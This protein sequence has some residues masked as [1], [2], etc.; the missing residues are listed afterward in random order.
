MP[1]GNFLSRA[2]K[3]MKDVSEINKNKTISSEE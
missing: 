2:W 1:H 3:M